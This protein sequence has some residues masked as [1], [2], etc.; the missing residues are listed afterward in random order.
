MNCFRKT[1]SSTR[2]SLVTCANSRLQ[3]RSRISVNTYVISGSGN[4]AGSLN[5]T[6]IS[7]IPAAQIMNKI[8]IIDFCK[9]SPQR[10]WAKIDK[11]N[12]YDFVDYDSALNYFLHISPSRASEAV[13]NGYKLEFTKASPD[14]V[15]YTLVELT[16]G[17]HTV[18][19]RNRILYRADRDYQ[20][21]SGD[22]LY[23]TP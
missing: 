7:S 15:T 1:S 2:K 16:R 18:T 8:E 22:L 13:D 20:D 11:F 23:H 9:S 17:E 4:I 21:W 12:T 6:Q 10:G 3:A 14:V 19:F 5:R